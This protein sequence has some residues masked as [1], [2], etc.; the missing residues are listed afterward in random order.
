MNGSDKMGVG[1]D[2]ESALLSSNPIVQGPAFVSG[3][4]YAQCEPAKS[5][6]EVFGAAVRR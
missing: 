6:V 2:G 1:A 5:G 3:L 4:G